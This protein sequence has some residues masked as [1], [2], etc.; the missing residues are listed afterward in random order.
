EASQSLDS[1]IEWQ[2]AAMPKDEATQK[3]VAAAAEMLHYRILSSQADHTT[4]PIAKKN[5]EDAAQKVLVQLSNERQELRGIIF[6]QM[7]ERMPKDAPVSGMDPLLLQGLMAKSYDESNKPPPATPDKVMLQRGLDACA[8]VLK[9]R[10]AAGITPQL[11]D[12]A[13]RLRPVL[14]EAMGNR[15]EAANTYLKYAQDNARTGSQAAQGALD[16]AG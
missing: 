9:R 16:D 10:G 8:E 4:D 5:A 2:K 11:L 15:I 6:Q 14:M 7:A 1:L 12:E 3:G 13:A